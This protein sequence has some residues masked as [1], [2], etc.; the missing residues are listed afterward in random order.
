LTRPNEIFFK[1]REKIK[2]IGI[3]GENFPN[4]ELGDLARPGSKNFDP[5]PKSTNWLNTESSKLYKLK[6]TLHFP[7]MLFDLGLESYF[8]TISYFCVNPEI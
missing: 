5:D 6:Y 8:I 2:K 7:Q 4:S 1:R 3:L